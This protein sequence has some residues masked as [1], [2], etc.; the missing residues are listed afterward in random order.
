MSIGYI[1]VIWGCAW[2]H[3]PAFRKQREVEL[4]EFEPAW[5]MYQV[6]V[7]QSYIARPCLGGAK[8]E[9]SIWDRPSMTERWNW[10]RD[11]HHDMGFILPP[12]L[13]AGLTA[14]SQFLL[15]LQP[16]SVT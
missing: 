4:C 9:G 7:S 12:T 13:G 14:P 10:K 8:W 15:L 5:P 16:S 2:W 6:S 3:I 1:S 11:S